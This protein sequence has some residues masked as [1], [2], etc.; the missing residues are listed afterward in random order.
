[1]TKLLEI[2]AKAWA[3]VWDWMQLQR[4]GWRAVNYPDEI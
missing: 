4:A 2:L 1:M 3:I